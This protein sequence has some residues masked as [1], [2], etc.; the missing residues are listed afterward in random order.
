MAITSAWRHANGQIRA[1]C[2]YISEKYPMTAGRSLVETS[3]TFQI[4]HCLEPAPS[5]RMTMMG[6]ILTMINFSLGHSLIRDR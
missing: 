3:Q 6:R 2:A 1:Q 4:L 5:A